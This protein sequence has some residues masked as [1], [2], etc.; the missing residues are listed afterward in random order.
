MLDQAI[1][2]YIAQ[3]RGFY[4]TIADPSRYVPGASIVRSMFKKKEVDIPYE[5][6]PIIS[7]WSK[8]ER[9]NLIWKSFFAESGIEPLVLW[10]EDA[11]HQNSAEVIAK[12]FGLTYP[13]KTGPRNL[14]KLPQLQNIR[15]KKLF[16]ADLFSRA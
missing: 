1:S 2:H 10:Y 3:K 15:L 8:L 11:Q 13:L 5:F 14:S 9:D 6:Q 16:L 7:E 12:H 4:H